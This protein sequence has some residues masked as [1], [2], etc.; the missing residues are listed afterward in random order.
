MGEGN[1]FETSVQFGCNYFRVEAHNY[2]LRGLLRVLA[3]LTWLDLVVARSFC[4]SLGRS[5]RRPPLCL[6]GVGLMRDGELLAV[7]GFIRRALGHVTTCRELR[8][9]D[10]SRRTFHLGQL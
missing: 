6:A 8:G 3:S 4:L 9:R 2:P 1:L 7:L 5:T 10:C